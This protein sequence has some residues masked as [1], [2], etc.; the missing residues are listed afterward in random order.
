MAAV[1]ALAVGLVV[2]GWAGAAARATLA[3]LDLIDLGAQRL[4]VFGSGIAAQRFS[5]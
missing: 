4:K 2:R 3:R 5:T 1:P